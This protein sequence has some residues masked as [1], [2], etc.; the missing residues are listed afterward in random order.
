[1]AKNWIAGA[2]KHPGALTRK[3]KEMGHTVQQHCAQPNL[4]TTTKRQ[5]NLAGT[6]RSMNKGRK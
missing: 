4:D 5:C 2:I 1:M 3:A 6:L